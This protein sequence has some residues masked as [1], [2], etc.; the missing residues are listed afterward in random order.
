M[1]VPVAG[2][3]TDLAGRWTAF[4]QAT[5]LLKRETL[6][7]RGRVGGTIY[8]LQVAQ[9][10]ATLGAQRGVLQAVA[11]DAGTSGLIAY[12]EAE[13][14]RTGYDIAAEYVDMRNALDQL[15][16]WLDVNLAPI[17]LVT[18]AA[19]AIVR[20]ELTAPQQTALDAQLATFAAQFE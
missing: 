7:L 15:V 2:S 17:P 3:T 20:T 10:G 18:W 19:G 12:A 16:L 8:A 4:K 1:A 13:L 6:A 9:Y 11:A 5:A 14:N